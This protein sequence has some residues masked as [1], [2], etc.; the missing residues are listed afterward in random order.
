MEQKIDNTNI[1]DL[2]IYTSRMKNGMED[3]L[4]FLEFLESPPL[5]VDYGCADGTLIKHIKDIYPDAICY[6]YDLNL[7]MLSMAK[8]RLKEYSHVYLLHEKYFKMHSL[9][10]SKKTHSEILNLSSVIHEIY[11]YGN[12]ESIKEFWKSVF[13]I[14]VE[15]IAIRDM[16]FQSSTKYPSQFKSFDEFFDCFM[17][18]IQKNGLE[19]LW[20]DFR[21][22]YPNKISYKL[23]THFLLK[24]KYVE[25]W[26][27][28]V[29]E[30][31][32]SLDKEQLMRIIPKSYEIE[33]E[34]DYILSYIH[35]LVWSDF[36][37]DLDCCTHMK[38]ILKKKEDIL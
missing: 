15:R 34:K 16:F 38:V 27:R 18:G 2:S 10:Q 6:G 22:V 5:L 33:Y 19:G 9:V 37:I 35:E 12:D 24:Y 23:I 8:E 32:F 21:K 3:K 4:Y 17:K 30:N 7:D 36:G 13:G 26:E 14:G 20:E 29:H 31:Y 11:S 1:K 25:N 28:E